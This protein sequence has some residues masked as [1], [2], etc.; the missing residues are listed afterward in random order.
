MRTKR[1]PKEKFSNNGSA[2]SLIE[3]R[4]GNQTSLKQVNP[5]LVSDLLPEAR[6][7]RSF[8]LTYC[9]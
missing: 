1:I 9:K 6:L 7:I 5:L 8:A 3:Q 4:S 2:F